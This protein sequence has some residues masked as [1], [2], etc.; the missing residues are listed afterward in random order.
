M[1]IMSEGGHAAQDLEAGGAGAVG[2]RLAAVDDIGGGC[3]GSEREKKLRAFGGETVEGGGMIVGVSLNGYEV[4]SETVA[5][6]GHRAGTG[7]RVED[8]EAGTRCAFQ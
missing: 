2:E 5:G 7:K 1:D 6:N 8:G 4:E 3:A